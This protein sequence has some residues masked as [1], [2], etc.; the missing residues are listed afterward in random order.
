LSLLINETEDIIKETKEKYIKQ[1]HDQHESLIM[2]KRKIEEES[3]MK[4]QKIQSLKQ[5]LQ[6]LQSAPTR[7]LE[8]SKS[9]HRQSGLVQKEERERMTNKLINTK[10]MIVALQQGLNYKEQALLS[11]ENKLEP[12]RQSLSR[13]KAL[14]KS[15]ADIER[16]LQD[17]NSKN[18]QLKQ[19]IETLRDEPDSND[20][21]TVD[22]LN[23]LLQSKKN[24][25]EL[26]KE[27]TRLLLL[28]ESQRANLLQNEN[29]ELKMKVQERGDEAT[30][31]KVESVTQYDTISKKQKL[32]HY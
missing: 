3:N 32:S 10:E 5:T 27:N 26:V 11:F 17:Q 21:D 9:L 24:E 29:R 28:Y 4:N 22:L 30:H 23:D 15:K 12:L 6:A 2:E 7:S 18:E 20:N 16:E 31:I 19:E 25:I 8:E 13:N 1:L 14:K